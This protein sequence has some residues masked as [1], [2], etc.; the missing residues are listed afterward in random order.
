MNNM[1]R[2]ENL[3]RLLDL[4]DEASQ[5]IREL[6][7]DDKLRWHSRELEGNSN[8]GWLYEEEDAD[9]N[10]IRDHVSLAIL[11]EKNALPA[12]YDPETI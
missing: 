7:E 1:T 2:L 4:I 8:G 12:D 11:K 6:P 3:A 10:Y 5:I 9:Y